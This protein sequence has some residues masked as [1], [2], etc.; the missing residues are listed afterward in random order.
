MERLSTM[1]DNFSTKR[2]TKYTAQ[3]LAEI[4]RVFSTFEV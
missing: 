1:S 2:K 3:Q 4:E